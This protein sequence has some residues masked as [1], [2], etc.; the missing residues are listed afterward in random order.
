MDEAKTFLKAVNGERLE[1]LY[2]LMLST[3]L[4]P[5]EAF[6]LAWSNVDLGKGLVT[7]KRALSR[8]PGGNVIGEGKTG[9]KGWRTVNLPPP[10]VNSLLAH[11]ERQDDER[12]LAGKVW[13]E[14][15]LVFCTPV[16]STL[17]PDN[18]RR[19]FKSLIDDAGLVPPISETPHSRSL[20][21][22]S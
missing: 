8:R 14:H 1:A 20:K 12:H 17:D 2:L 22:P 5:G 16:G 15:D 18:H 9:K 13:Q 3:G 19:A 6:G 11:R 4:R 21:F 10:V 7:I